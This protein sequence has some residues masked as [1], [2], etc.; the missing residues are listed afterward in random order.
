[1]GQRQTKAGI[2]EP[3]LRCL[4]RYWYEYGSDERDRGSSDYRDFLR[5]PAGY[6]WWIVKFIEQPEN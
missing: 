2:F 4:H 5:Q 3:L 6:E 1:M